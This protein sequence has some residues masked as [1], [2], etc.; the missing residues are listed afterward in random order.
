MSLTKRPQI[1]AWVVAA[2][3]LVILAFVLPTAK[4]SVQVPRRTFIGQ[5]NA[6]GVATSTDTSSSCAYIIFHDEIVRNCPGSR[7]LEFE[8]IGPFAFFGHPD[9]GLARKLVILMPKFTKSFFT[10]SHSNC[11][12]LYTVGGKKNFALGQDCG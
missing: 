6:I 12:R 4:S 1:V 3:I 9:L 2:T 11:C 7:T 10:F 5:T 8:H